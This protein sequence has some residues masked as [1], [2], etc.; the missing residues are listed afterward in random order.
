MT[1]PTTLDYLPVKPLPRRPVFSIS[2]AVLT[3]LPAIVLTIASLIPPLTTYVPSMET[4]YKDFAVPLPASTRLWLSISWWFLYDFG[5]IY[6]WS[7]AIAIP[8]LWARI[9]TPIQDPLQRRIR[10]LMLV[11]VMQFVLGLFAIFVAVALFSP[12]YWLVK[13]VIQPVPH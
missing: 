8:F 2:A 5:W 13:N 1:Q 6:V 7:V 12:Y 10:L 4:I 3:I 9:V 11:I